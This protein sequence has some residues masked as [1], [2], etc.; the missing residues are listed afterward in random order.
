MASKKKVDNTVEIGGMSYT[1]RS[2]PGLTN[3]DGRKLDGQIRYADMAIDLEASLDPQAAF[4]TLWH[5]IVHALFIQGGRVEHDENDV[6]ALGYGIA[7]V[8]RANG[9][10]VM[11]S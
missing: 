1:V 2:V 6:V 9:D 5:E 10:K 11:P 7:G 8:L 4:M 3:G